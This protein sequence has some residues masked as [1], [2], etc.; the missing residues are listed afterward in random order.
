MH[1]WEKRPPDTGPFFLASRPP[2]KKTCSKVC[3]TLTMSGDAIYFFTQKLDR[4][5]HE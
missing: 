1:C 4:A 2:P 5:D 3:S